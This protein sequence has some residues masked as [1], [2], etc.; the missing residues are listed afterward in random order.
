M[1]KLM[2]SSLLIGT[3][4]TFSSATAQATADQKL[5][6]EILKIKAID[7]HA[8][9]LRVTAAGEKPD[10]EYDAL[11]LD[12]IEP[13][14]VPVR[15]NPGNPE[16]IG[17]WRELFNYQY[18][19]MSE[20][21]V[22]ELVAI[23]Q[24]LINEKGERYPEWILEK[25]NIETMFA[26]RIAMGRGL[27]APH[28]RWVSFVDPLLFPLSNDAAKKSNRDYAGFYPAEEKLLH[29][30]LTE[31]N[32]TELPASLGQ[33]LKQVVTPTLERQKRMGVVALKYE[34]AYLRLLDFGLPQEQLATTT[35]AKF[36]RGGEP[37]PEEYK[38]LQDYIF[39]YIATEAGRL[40]LAIHIHCINGAGGYYRQSGS[41]PALLETTFNDQ[42]LRKTNFL[43]IHG[44]YPFTKQTLG[45]LS[46][47]N[48]FADISAQTFL[49][50]PRELSEVLRNWLETYPEKVV[51]GTDAFSFS[52][53]VDWPEV[54][55]LSNTSARK[56]LALALT[57][58]M[59]DGEI[60]RERA[61]ELARMVLRENALKLYGE[62]LRLAK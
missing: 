43:I 26:N 37:P 38:A 23:K 8:H 17:A 34:A 5:Y 12:A 7:N 33:Y 9:P 25:L 53:A 39:H 29:T 40:G 50:Y 11:P 58:M 51:F 28:F 19:D 24:K 55:W 45:L 20:T 44:G 2:L 22:R 3:A 42:E 4:F 1:R 54:A 16:F 32:Q 30:Y 52:P 59:N 21:H 47:P 36:V 31:S 56:A 27:S 61:I 62:S 18:N 57:G 15:L 10:D 49:I 35:Y 46:K 60:T 48:V 41:N 6:D 14:P 13:F